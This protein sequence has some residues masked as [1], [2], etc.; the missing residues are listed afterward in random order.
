VYVPDVVRVSTEFVVGLITPPVYVRVVMIL[1]P[2]L[3]NTVA[4]VAA[5]AS[6]KLTVPDTVAAVVILPL[7]L[8]NSI[9]AIDELIHVNV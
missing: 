8:K 7:A 5:L 9:V 4:L 2:V 3:V 1:L 6:V